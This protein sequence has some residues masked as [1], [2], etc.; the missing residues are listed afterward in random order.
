MQI[1]KKDLR[2]GAG[3]LK[4]KPETTT[5]LYILTKIIDVN[6]E[7]VART[8]RRI[9]KMGTGDRSGDKGERISVTIRLVVEEVSFSESST[10]PRLRIRGKIKEATDERVSINSWHTF[11]VESGTIITVEKTNW[12]DYHFKL[13]DEATKA[14]E[15]PTILFVALE[16]GKATL[17]SADNFQVKIHHHY[18][19][20]I[21]RKSG[22]AK[23]RDQAIKQFFSE[24][25]AGL[26]RL[27]S[28]HHGTLLLGGPHMNR[29]TFLHYLQEKAPELRS[30]IIEEDASSGDERGISEMIKR[31]VLDKI[32]SNYLFMEEKKLIDEFKN[33]IQTDID[34]TSYGLL[35]VIHVSE[36]NAIDTL[37]LTDKLLRSTDPEKENLVTNLLQRVERTKG[38]IL[39]V[40]HGT[41][42]GDFLKQFGDIIALL[43]FPVHVS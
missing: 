25:L 23:R 38:K 37:L 10:S 17:A 30:R 3:I 20:R 1:L 7:A 12:L 26:K 39:V 19:A 6:D 34:R 21:P 43:R 18:R 8:K 36:M 9:H 32:A 5:D 29:Q 42:N 22:D 15:L 27:D 14:A 13:L 24:I 40:D 28:Q 41:E 11:N 2:A 16:M 31:G 35:P 33:R 4:I